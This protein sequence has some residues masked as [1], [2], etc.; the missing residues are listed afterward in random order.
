MQPITRN[1]LLRNVIK[2][3]LFSAF[4]MLLLHI[5][6]HWSLKPTLLQQY[7]HIKVLNKHEMQLSTPK[8]RRAFITLASSDEYA[9]AA[10][11]LHYTLKK[12]GSKE[13]STIKNF[14]F[15]T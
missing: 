4:V 14:Q 7:N 10:A 12:V 15:H 11:V 8:I 2:C 13:G 1:G 3:V 9:M 5:Q 6:S